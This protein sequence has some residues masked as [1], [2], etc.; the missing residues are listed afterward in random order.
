MEK[1]GDL[2]SNYKGAFDGHLTFGKKPC[3]LIIDFVKVIIDFVHVIKKATAGG[4]RRN[5]ISQIEVLPPAHNHPT[6][7]CVGVPAAGLA[8]LRWRRGGPGGHRA[9]SG[10]GPQERGAGHP[11]QRGVAAGRAQRWYAMLGRLIPELNPSIDRFI[12]SHPSTHT[13]HPIPRRILPQDP[14]AA[15][16]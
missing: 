4:A 2:A 1:D 10:A 6:I 9:A 14:P 13:S 7:L 16:L 3:L 11:H 5:W 12:D 15:H 8:H